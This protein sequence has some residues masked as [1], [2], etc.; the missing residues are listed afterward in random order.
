VSTQPTPAPGSIGPGA[1]E[2]LPLSQTPAPA[3]PP[4]SSLPAPAPNPADLGL[5]TPISTPTCDGIGIVVVENATDPAT[6]RDVIAAALQKNP[7]AQYLR[8]DRSC[9]SLRPVD[10]QGN[11]I[12][13][14]YVVVGQGKSSVCNALPGYPDRYGK[15]LDT[16][17]DP[18]V[19]IWPAD[20]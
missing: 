16:V 19:P 20:C 11:L 10:N 7:G 17:S 14:A 9:P 13:A 1:I 8:T 12:Y 2:E 18:N 3:T 6:N 5:A 15:V 4:T